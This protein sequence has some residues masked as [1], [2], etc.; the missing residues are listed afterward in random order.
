MDTT[1]LLGVALLAV[2]ATDFAL[3]FLVIGPRI[4]DPR[5]RRILQATLAAGGVLMVAVGLLAL[6]GV[7]GPF[8]S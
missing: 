7:I 1:H 6:A 4:R 8:G 3:A 2:G 5:Q